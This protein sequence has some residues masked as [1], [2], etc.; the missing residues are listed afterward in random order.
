MKELIEA[1]TILSN[2]TASKFPTNCSHDLLWVDVDPE[3][4]SA[5]D[6]VKLEELGF[7]VSEEYPEGFSS[8]RFGSC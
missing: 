4:V 2:Y 1:L 7:L 8:Y 5:D 3:L 6:K